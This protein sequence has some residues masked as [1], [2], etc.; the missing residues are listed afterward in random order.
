MDISTNIAIDVSSACPEDYRKIVSMIRNAGYKLS[1]GAAIPGLVTPGFHKHLMFNPLHNLW[2][3]YGD[4][5]HPNVVP[6]HY[7]LRKHKLSQIYE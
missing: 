2:W 6:Y 1:P 4:I 3:S 7:L 5:I